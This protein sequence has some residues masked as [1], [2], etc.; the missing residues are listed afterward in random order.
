MIRD[1]TTVITCHVL[2]LPHVG[3][4]S[5]REFPFEEGRPVMSVV[6]VPSL[7]YGQVTKP[8]PVMARVMLPVEEG[9]VLNSDARERCDVTDLG[10]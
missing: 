7:R 4:L 3:T 1:I 6:P 10:A 9:Q 2:P 5:F 8:S